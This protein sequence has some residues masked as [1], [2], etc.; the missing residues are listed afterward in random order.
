MSPIWSAK[1]NRNLDLT[2]KYFMHDPLC[3]MNGYMA[4]C[5]SFATTDKSLRT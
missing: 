1:F 4:T 3:T 2:S 5:N